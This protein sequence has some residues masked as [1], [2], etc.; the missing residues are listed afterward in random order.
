MNSNIFTRQQACFY[1][2]VNIDADVDTIKKA[3][4]YKAKMYHPDANPSNDT[5]EYYIMVQKS[6][7]YLINNPYVPVQNNINNSIN[8]NMNISPKYN[9]VVRPA[10]V[11][12]SDE[13]TRRRFQAQK[14][15][16]KERQKVRKWE[17]DYRSSK[18]HAELEKQFGKAYADTKVNVPKTKEEEA[19][20]KIR[21]IWIAE[22]IRRQIELDKKEKEIENRRKLYQAFMQQKLNDEV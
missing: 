6:Y 5:S 15:S 8:N 1:L 13:S 18:K 16:E 2:G 17:A 20:D 19:L 10:K 7:E 22:T 12:Q 3:Y 14:E 11:F 9:A 4:R 21:A